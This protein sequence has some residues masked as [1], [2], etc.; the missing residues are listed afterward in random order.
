MDIDHS[1]ST[2]KNWTQYKDRTES[3]KRDWIEILLKIASSLYRVA[4]PIHV[5]FYVATT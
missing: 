1:L 2:V 4:L 3:K 5:W